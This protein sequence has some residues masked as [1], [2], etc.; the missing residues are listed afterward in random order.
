[1]TRALA[2]GSLIVLLL[3]ASGCGGGSERSASAPASQPQATRTAAP[4]SP[5]P[6][7]GPAPTAGRTSPERQP[8]GAGDERSARTEVMLTGQGGVVRPPLVR[9]APYIAVRVALAAADGRSYG[10]AF[11]GH[12]LRAAG[13]GR[14]T[15]DFAGLRP[16]RGLFAKP[17]DGSRNGVRILAVAR[18]GP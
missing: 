1:L 17:L 11:P 5:P 16:G 4:G 13:G 6:R 18:P 8:G 7:T 12:A 2:G 9:V 15:A 14:A 10:L 3:V